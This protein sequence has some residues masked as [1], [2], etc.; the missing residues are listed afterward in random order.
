MEHEELTG[1][2]PPVVVPFTA[3]GELDETAFRQE[4]R[5]LL[6]HDIDG[7]SSGG[8]TGEGALLSDAELRR[9]LELINEENHRRLPVYAGIIRNATRDVV[10][11]GLDAKSL[12]VKALLVTPVFYHGATAEQNIAFYR[13]IG[14]RVQLPII[15]YNVVPTNPISPALFRRIVELDWVIGIKEVNP[16]NLA[17][18]AATSG[19]AYRVYA[20][21]D[22]LLYSTYVAGACGAISALVTVAPALCVQ[23]WKAFKASRQAEAMDIQRQ[24]LPLV[25]A[26]FQAPFPEKIKTLL[27]LQGRA[28]GYPRH[29]MQL[30]G[31]EQQAS[32]SRALVE[33][34]ISVR[35]NE[36]I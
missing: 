24:L 23:Q 31:G 34:G 22:H 29:P 30:S 9:C 17:E 28:G 21:C 19:G 6:G 36:H 12:G 15:V 16:I 2:V 18:L 8:S 33:A 14:E 25:T 32:L 7:L 35:T 26:Y 10:R 1:M 5:Y 3:A 13:E 27:H 11:A 20:A 4:I